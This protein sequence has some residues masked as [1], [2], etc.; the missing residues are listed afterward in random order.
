MEIDPQQILKLQPVRF[1]WVATDEEDIG[2]FAEDVEGIIPA[3]VIYDQDGNPEAVDY[4]KVSLYLLEIIRTQQQKISA[5]EK[6][7]AELENR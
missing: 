7:F 3:L 4:S 1:E 6:Q 5:L 2:L